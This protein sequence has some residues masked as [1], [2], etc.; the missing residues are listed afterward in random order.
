MSYQANTTFQFRY[1][2]NLLS[3]FRLPNWLE[4]ARAKMG[5][6]SLVVLLVVG[7]VFQ[8]NAMATRGYVVHNLEQEIAELQSETE[9]IA[10]QVA[11]YQSM[12]SI[13]KRLEKDN[14]ISA[15]PAKYVKAPAET[16][17][18]RR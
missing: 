13:Q 18:A 5:I 2:S 12:T 6:A 17:V 3:I 11:S 1:S 14:Y 8:T 7:Y 16:V 10:T 9:K 4:S 15:R